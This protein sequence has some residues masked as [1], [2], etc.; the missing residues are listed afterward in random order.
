MGIYTYKSVSHDGDIAQANDH[1]T[2]RGEKL[3]LFVATA[4]ARNTIAFDRLLEMRRI[5]NFTPTVFLISLFMRDRESPRWV[6][7]LKLER[8][9]RG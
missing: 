4:G 3:Q 9:Y 6:L 8:N 1:D 5:A 2:G 7:R